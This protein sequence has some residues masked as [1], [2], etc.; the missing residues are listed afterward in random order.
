[1]ATVISY[2]RIHSKVANLLEYA[3]SSPTIMVRLD[4]LLRKR[5]GTTTIDKNVTNAEND[6]KIAWKLG[7]IEEPNIVDSDDTQHDGL[8]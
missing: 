5:L 2:P 7:S 6:V 1:M 8:V 4:S 3:S